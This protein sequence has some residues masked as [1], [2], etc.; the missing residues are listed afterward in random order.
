MEDDMSTRPTPRVFE[1]EFKLTLCRQMAAGERGCTDLGREHGI[2]QSVLY[3]WRAEYATHGEDAFSGQSGTR[4]LPPGSSRTEALL[5]QRIAELE[6]ALGKATVEN[7]I[8][9]KGRILA[10]SP[11]ARR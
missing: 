1:R 11:S 8:L 9:K 4:P 10:A 5:R 7:Q 2:A 3:R 6:R